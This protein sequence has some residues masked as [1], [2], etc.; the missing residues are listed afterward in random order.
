MFRLRSCASSR[1]IESYSRSS[2]SPCVSASRMPSVISLMAV[3]LPTW[4]WKRTLQ[5]TTPPSS[6]PSSS[7]MRAATERAAMRRGW[8]WPM[9]PLLPRPISSS[10]FGSCVVLPEPVSPQTITTGWRSTA[11]WISSRRALIGNPSS[12]R[13]RLIGAHPNRRMAYLF[14]LQRG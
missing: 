7:A 14:S 1:M 6:V 5:P 12:N 13:M 9:R 2:R 3:R 8:V 10:I 11:A 4:S